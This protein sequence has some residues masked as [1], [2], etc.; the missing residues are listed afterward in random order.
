MIPVGFSVDFFLLFK[1]R[2]ASLCIWNRG[3]VH[4]GMYSVHTSIRVMRLESLSIIIVTVTVPPLCTQAT[5]NWRSTVTYFR[6]SLKYVPVHTS[7]FCLSLSGSTS[8]WLGL[9]SSM[10]YVLKTSTA[11][12]ST[13]Y[14]CQ[15]C[16]PECTKYTPGM[17]SCCFSVCSAYP[18]VSLHHEALF[19][20]GV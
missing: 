9:G 16:V 19:G 1:L 8:S 14:F 2:D 18:I 5:S 13:Q 10:Y 15:K 11:V 3:W 7:S 20:L 6:L 12:T 4:T 17:S